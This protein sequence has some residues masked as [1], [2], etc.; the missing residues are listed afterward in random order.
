MQGRDVREGEG[1]MLQ[2]KRQNHSTCAG[3][4]SITG[5]FAGRKGLPAEKF[6][7]QGEPA[8]AGQHVRGQRPAKNNDPPP[9]CAAPFRCITKSILLMMPRSFK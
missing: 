2:R 8:D 9:G 5:E 7:M 3:P 6:G 4:S 1:E